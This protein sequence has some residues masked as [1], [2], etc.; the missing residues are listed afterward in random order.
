MENIDLCEYLKDM[1]KDTILYSVIHGKVLLSNIEEN[2]DYPIEVSDNCNSLSYFTKEGKYY[3]MYDGECVLFPSKEM[4]DWTKFFKHGDVVEYDNII[5][6]FDSWAD[7][8]Y[9]TFYAKYA[10]VNGFMYK[11]KKCSTKNYSKASRKQ[12]INFIKRI[13]N[14][15][16]GKL[17]LETLEIEHEELKSNGSL[18]P[19]DKV[20]VRDSDNKKWRIDIFSLYRSGNIFP[21]V[22]LRSDWKQCISYNEET[23]HLLG[24][25]A[26]Y[27]C[28]VDYGKDYS[29]IE[30]GNE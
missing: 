18:K 11:N 19:F 22:C 10:I 1:P 8:T 14:S 7:T 27:Q 12:S 9:T 16:N 15:Q 13:E 25:E 23:A 6:M 20:L 29:K 30:T 17:N 24:T 21:Y 3:R 4:R 2:Y 28:I 26:D 5:A